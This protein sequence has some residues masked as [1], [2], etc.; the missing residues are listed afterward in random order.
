MAK[1]HIN[2]DIQYTLRKTVEKLVPF[3]KVHLYI[4]IFWMGTQL[5]LESVVNV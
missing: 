1:S 3:Q 2:A 4:S 5:Q